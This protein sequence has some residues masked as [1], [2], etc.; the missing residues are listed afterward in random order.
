M[1][2]AYNTWGSR[3]ATVAAL[4]VL[5][6]GW[7]NP[8]HAQFGKRLKDAVKRTAEDK[9]ITKA[10]D[11]E[12]KAIDS[13]TAG[14]GKKGD[15]TAAAP[16]G[17]TSAAPAA[18]AG[19]PAAGAAGATAAATSPTDKKAWANY[20]FVPGQRTLFFTDFTE[21][22]VGN[23]PQRLEFK[24]GQ[25]EIVEFEGGQRALKASSDGV[26]SIPLPEVLPEKFTLEFDVINRKSQGVAANTI[27]IYG[28]TEAKSSDQSIEVGWGHNGVSTLGG[29]VE[30]Q[31]ISS[32]DADKARYVGHP[33][34]FR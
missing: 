17:Q 23:F 11:A 21:D 24:K 7:A 10:T 27:T 3:L 1:V 22:Q 26:F 15:S 30:N 25:L 2:M 34:S 28:G 12:G 29:G 18:T 32:K 4:A 16:A 6:V 19:A 13:A 31:W 33:A 14:G 5:S 20:D 9:A 8:A